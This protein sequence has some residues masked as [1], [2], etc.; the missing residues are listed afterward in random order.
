MYVTYTLGISSRGP[1]T[2]FYRNW[3]PSFFRFRAWETCVISPSDC[4]EVTAAMRSVRN[5]R[6]R[7]L[8]R[9]FRELPIRS[10]V[11]WSDSY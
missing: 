9:P 3:L 6:C 5:G 2:P 4:R 11:C 8:N 7:V 10:R 1:F